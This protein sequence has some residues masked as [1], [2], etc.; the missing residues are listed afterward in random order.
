MTKVIEQ[1]TG[2]SWIRW[3]LMRDGMVVRS[4]EGRNTT[5]SAM[6]TAMANYLAYA[7]TSRACNRVR[8]DSSA[9]AVLSYCTL[10]KSNFA[11][12]P[13]GTTFIGSYT[14]SGTS[15]TAAT[16]KLI[17]YDAINADVIYCT[18]DISP[19]LVM[20]DGDVLNFS[21]SK[22]YANKAGDEGTKAAVS[23]Y[24]R[25][26]F[27]QATTCTPVAT[28]TITGSG[29]Y[30]LDVAISP[31]LSGGTVSWGI[32]ATNASGTDDTIT[33]VEIVNNEGTGYFDKTGLSADWDNGTT[34]H[35]TFQWVLSES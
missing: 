33:Q 15:K 34:R 35:Y 10:T 2:S 18:Y 21:W 20:A 7:G 17:Y 28:A 12:P 29:A 26:C 4:G 13:I 3:E 19:D 30:S 5:T 9:G 27:Y 25:T 23:T 11:G 31:S 16:M 14:N 6:L 24:L 22:T 1:N 8:V 32:E